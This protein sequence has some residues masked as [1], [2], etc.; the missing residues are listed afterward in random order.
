MKNK[1]YDK[2]KINLDNSTRRKLNRVKRSCGVGERSAL[3]GDDI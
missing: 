3:G 2:S 1:Q